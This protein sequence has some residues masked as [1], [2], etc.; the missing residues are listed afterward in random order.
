[1]KSHVVEGGHSMCC[2]RRTVP[3]DATLLVEVH[4]VNSQRLSKESVG[5][6]DQSMGSRPAATRAALA[7]EKG[8]LPK[9][10]L[11]ADKGDG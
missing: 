8:L 6:S 2:S 9:N 1:M 11:W 3:I 4:P 7:W 5:Q 10:P